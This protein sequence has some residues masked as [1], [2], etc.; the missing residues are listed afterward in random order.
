MRTLT[1]SEIQQMLD[2]HKAWLNN[3]NEGKRAD[4]SEYDLRSADLRSADLRYAD[5]IF[6][7]LRSADLRSA[8]LRYADLFF[9]DLR[10]ADLLTFQYQQHQA[11]CTGERLIIGC[12]D[13][14]LAEWAANYEQIGKDAGYTDLQI[15]I[16]GKFIEMCIEH[17]ATIDK[18]DEEVAR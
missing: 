1:R 15:A 4:F 16:Y 5:L 6:A 18:P 13:H 11:Y 2:N 17:V 12:E 14:S 3:S 7:D 10:A 8:D 9:A